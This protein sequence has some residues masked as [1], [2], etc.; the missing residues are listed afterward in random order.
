MQLVIDSMPGNAGKP[1][2]RAR[3]QTATEEDD[4]VQP[5][6]NDASVACAVFLLLARRHV[7]GDVHPTLDHALCALHMVWASVDEASP[8][9]VAR[10]SFLRLATP[11][12][13]SLTNVKGEPT[14]PVHDEDALQNYSLPAVV[15]QP[16]PA[17]E[18]HRACRHGGPHGSDRDR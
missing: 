10:Q 13:V 12:A 2:K 6:G 18:R 4:W 17:R 11:G 8:M 14:V 3:E 16:R 15:D 1:S 7:P 9:E 5:I